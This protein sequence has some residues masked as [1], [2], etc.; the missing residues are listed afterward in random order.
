MT[1]T[2]D[3]ELASRTGLTRGENDRAVLLSGETEG[4]SVPERHRKTAQ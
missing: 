1:G 3:D 4:V 2:L